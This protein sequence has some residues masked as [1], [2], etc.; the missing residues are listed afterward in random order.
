MRRVAALLLSLLVATPAGAQTLRVGI[1][2]DPNVLDPAVSGSFVERTVFSA[3]CDKLVDVGPD[4]AFRPELATRWEWAPDG[5]SLTLTIRRVRRKGPEQTGSSRIRS[6]R[7]AS[8]AGDMIIP[9]RS[10]ST[11]SSGAKGS[12]RRITTVAGSGAST[13]L[14]GRS[15]LRR[16]DSRAPR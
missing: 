13:A 15:S 12:E 6:P 9:A 16:R 8:A 1:S 4:L 11:E 5:L 2:S 10:D 3:L 14:T 7:R